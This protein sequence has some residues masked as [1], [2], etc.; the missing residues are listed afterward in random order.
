MTIKEMLYTLWKKKLDEHY[1]DSQVFVYTDLPSSAGNYELRSY[2]VEVKGN[3]VVA[4]AQVRA[5][6]AIAAG[7]DLINVTLPTIPADVP[8][9]NDAR[10]FG[11]ANSSLVIGSFSRNAVMMR[12]FT[13]SIPANQNIGIAAIGIRR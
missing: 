8:N 6:K 2:V 12:P 4:T 5:L 9:F 3:L 10:S 1:F 13:S 7:S 11:W